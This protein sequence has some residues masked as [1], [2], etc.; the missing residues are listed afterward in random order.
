MS[1]T[2]LT[3][4]CLCGAVR[5]QVTGEPMAVSHCHCKDCRRAAGAPFITWMTLKSGDFAYTAGAP[6]EY[7]SSS[8]VRRGFCGSCGTTL[9]YRG[10]THPEEIDISAAALDDP[11][12]VTPDDHLWIGSKLSWI[13]LADGLP[14][15][16]KD[17]WDH[18]Y[19][20]RR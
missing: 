6:K 15:L 2:K 13:E 18:G 1:F 5:F 14:R 9:A 20:K 8:G 11:E 19:P 16:E 17:H 4:G 7:E 3:G 12:A 10:A